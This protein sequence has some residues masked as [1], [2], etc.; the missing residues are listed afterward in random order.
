MSGTLAFPPPKTRDVSIGC[1]LAAAAEAGRLPKELLIVG[2][3][4]TGKTFPVLCMLHVLATGYAGLRILICRQTR[5]SLTNSVLVTFEQEVLAADGMG[6]LAGSVSRSTRMSYRYPNGSEVALGGLDKP[7]RILST[8]WDL[9]FVNEAIETREDAWDALGSRLDRPGRPR[10]FGYLLADTNP[11]APNHWLKT[12][13]DEGRTSLWETSHKA[14]PAMFDGVAWTPAG[15]AYLDRLDR[16]RGTRRKRLKEGLWASGEGTWF[17]TF[18]TSTHVSETAAYDPRWPVHF[19][20]DS[21]VETGAVWFQVREGVDGPRVTVFADYYKYNLPAYDVGLELLA[22]TRALCGRIDRGTQDPSG[23]SK[24]P[25]GPT[26]TGEYRRAGLDLNGWPSYSGSVSDGLNLLESFVAVDPPALLIHPRCSHLID[27][28]ANYK[29]KRYRD[30]WADVPEDPQHPYEELMDA[31]RGGLQDKFPE[32]R[33]PEPKLLRV[34]AR[35]V[36]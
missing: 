27:A 24:S 9:I 22:L 30:Q 18:D 26:V 3:A 7:D 28:F 23:S 16:L 6:W 2:P 31:L 15:L 5:A 13:C 25:T 19:A 10:R 29:R 33:R 12:R 21:G 20:V 34:P 32:G 1:R 14:N 4:G 36:F 11:G 8:G 35:R 17:D